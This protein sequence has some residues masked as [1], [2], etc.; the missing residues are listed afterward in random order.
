MRQLLDHLSRTIDGNAKK[1]DAIKDSVSEIRVDV[2]V[3]KDRGG[4]EAPSPRKEKVAVAVAGGWLG[5]LIV[6]LFEAVTNLLQK[7]H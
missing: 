3:L 6:A 4:V 2:A 5:A 7:G 1:I